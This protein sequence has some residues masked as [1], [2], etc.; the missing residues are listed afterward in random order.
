VSA[1]GGAGAGDSGSSSHNAVAKGGSASGQ[2][3][4][5]TVRGEKGK[6]EITIPCG[7]EGKNGRGGNMTDR[8]GWGWTAGGRRTTNDASTFCLTFIL[9]RS[10]EKL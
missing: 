4:V 2:S 10:R 5:L 7:F 3:W 6:E 9:F 1:N 8:G